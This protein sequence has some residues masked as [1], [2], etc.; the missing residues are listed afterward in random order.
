M[1]RVYNSLRNVKVN[2]IGQILNTVFRFACRTVFIYTLGQ[3][4]LGISSLYTNILTLLS[5]S[6]LG[7]ANAIIFSMYRPL[8]EGDTE[9]IKSIMRFYRNAYRIIGLV[10]LGVGLCLTPFLPVLMTDTTDKINI[11]L[12][13]MLYLAQTV[14]TY[15]F[16]AYKQSLLLA[17]QKKYKVDLIMYGMQILLCIT[18][19][20]VL[21]CTKSFFV[22][23]VLAI[24]CGILINLLI[25]ITVDREYPYLKEQPSK[26][27]GEE[28]KN[29]FSQVRAMFLYKICNT[30][31]VATDNLIISSHIS[32]LM[33]GLYS[34]YLMIIVAIET[35]LSSVLHAFTGSLGNLYATENDKKNEQVFR[36]LNLVNLWY[37]TFAAVCCLVLFQPFITLWIGEGYLFEPIVVFI[38]V[39]NF[40]TNHMQ[41]VVQIYKD[42]TGLFVRGKYRPVATV[43]LNLGLSLILVRVMGIAG[44]FLGSIISRLCTTW[45]YDG[46][47]I[48]RHAFHISPKRFYLDC[49]ATAGIIVGL[50]A[51]ILGI[52]YGLGLPVTWGGL[53]IRAIF[54]LII[55][56]GVLYLVYRRREEFTIV[57]EKVK[58][59][60]KKKF[61]R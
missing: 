2:L 57:S 51:A 22:Y 45:V 35:V 50:T 9:K 34:N 42:T 7:I 60:I 23:T 31:G 26:L 39:M 48:H 13:Y 8:A 37:I 15:F 1:G 28:K 3:E 44:V 33:V 38:I 17:D 4:F 55:I 18:Q 53:I 56:N 10:I 58:E 36:C 52:C 20:I 24:G 6:E 41:G 5:I 27:P 54:C 32:V 14:V 46:W 19:M 59:I 61:G 47:L 21:V 25:S 12:Y 40:A 43:I 11:Y 30:V 16:F 49:V 29:I